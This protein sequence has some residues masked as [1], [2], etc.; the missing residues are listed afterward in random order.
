MV[1][2]EIYHHLSNK[3]VACNKPKIKIYCTSPSAELKLMKTFLFIYL[4]IH[5]QLCHQLIFVSSIFG[6]DCLMSLSAEPMML[7]LCVAHKEFLCPGKSTTSFCSG[8]ILSHSFPFKSMSL[9]PSCSHLMEC[10]QEAARLILWQTRGIKQ[11]SR[12]AVFSAR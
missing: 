1:F 2:G 4:F 7:V 12:S 5:L 9:S 6:Y 3:S 8:C 10:S 11:Q